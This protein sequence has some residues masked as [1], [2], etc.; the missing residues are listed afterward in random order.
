MLPDDVHVG[1]SLKAGFTNWFILLGSE[2]GCL[3]IVH[4]LRETDNPLKSIK[5]ILNRNAVMD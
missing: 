2:R 5:S 3:F 4:A 1:K